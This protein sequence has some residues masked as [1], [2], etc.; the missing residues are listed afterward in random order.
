MYRSLRLAASMALVVACLGN[1]GADPLTPS[2][3]AAAQKPAKGGGSGGGKGGGKGGSTA[4]GT[5]SLRMVSDANGNGQPDWNDTV[6]FD[7][8]TTA[9]SPFVSVN[10]YQGASW[11][12]SASI[13]FFDAYPWA[14]EFTLNASSWSG[15]AASC[16]AR[17]YTSVDGSSSTTLSTVD[18]QAGAGD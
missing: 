10:C 14:Q 1:F 8:T 15:G 18:F 6:T 7:V 9:T 3:S 17:L 11:V 16:T 13:G 4:T 5:L 2:L 12:Y